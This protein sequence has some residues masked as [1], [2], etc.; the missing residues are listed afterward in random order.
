MTCRRDIKESAAAINNRP[1][2][3]VI[4]YRI[5]RYATFR[6]AM[7]ESINMKLLQ[8]SSRESNDYGIV[9]IE[10]WAYLA[11]ILAYY[12]ERIANEAYIRTT[13]LR[14]SVIALTEFIDY[15]LAPGVSA[16]TFIALIADKDKSG[17]IQRG[18]RVQSKVAGE[19]VKTFQT[20]EAITIFSS[21]NT[22]KLVSEKPFQQLRKDDQQ[23][24]LEGINLNMKMGDRILIIDVDRENDPSSRKWDV[25]Q[26]T[27]VTEYDKKTN[28]KFDKKI[29][30]NYEPA[31]N[32][33]VYAFREI[34]KP[35]GNNAPDYNSLTPEQKKIIKLDAS[36]TTLK[37]LAGDDTANPLI[38]LDSVYGKVK[39]GSYIAAINAIKPD[40]MELYKVKSVNEI[41]Y[42]N[43]ALSGKVT[44]AVVDKVAGMENFYIRE[45]ILLC[46]NESFIYATKESDFI[47]TEASQELEVKGVI[48]N[49]RIGAYIVISGEDKDGKPCSEVRRV[50]SVK[51]DTSTTKI[52]LDKALANSYK[53]DSAI[54][55]GNVVPASYGEPVKNEIVGSGD[56]SVSFQKFMLKKNPVTF[57]PD[58]TA[59]H[60]AKNSLELFVND[61]LW[62]ERDTFMDSGPADR[63]YITEI[64]EKDEM[65]VIFGDGIIGA[66]PPT[67]RDNITA[68]YR[69]GAG[70]NTSVNTI[71]GMVDSSPFLK[72]VLNPL[73]ASGGSEHE[74]NEKA[75]ENAPMQLRTFD[76]A[77]SLEDYA[78][79][80]RS[81]S[82]ITKARAFMEWE[83]EKQVVQL[84]VAL[85]QGEKL[86]D[87]IKKRLRAFLDMRRDANQPLSIKDYEP[88]KIEVAL[89]VT[90]KNAY[91]NTKVKKEVEEILGKFFAFEELDFGMSI[92]LSDIYAVVEG[93]E[94][95]AN[96]VVSKFRR[97]DAT[98]PIEEDILIKNTQIAQLDSL[99]VL[100]KGGIE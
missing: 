11:D 29:S 62:E 23:V 91:F 33:K 47:L 80:A 27:E 26:L 93:I 30:H 88:V 22:L 78:Y 79:I 6:S 68:Q 16:T 85:D 89:E 8:W 98:D 46:I 84:I 92:H 44:V 15:R 76:R 74:T 95:I 100:A 18:F 70:G 56:A 1:Y 10:M 19:P 71:T 64:N 13:V 48:E 60:G 7:L 24:I 73:P 75:K 40:I 69:R 94:G 90:V 86:A 34:A 41:F 67:G 38:H 2:M 81:F 31:Q 52:G 97:K 66:K 17:I 28:V 58:P 12:Q 42:I 35:F 77:I 53:K 63:H 5:G 82:G 39:M 50:A 55:Y 83:G 99:D 51:P 20:E 57:L 14:E 61:V 49:L 43:F 25:L 32:P 4:N 36:S 65:M 96:F 54:I 37:D 72:S 87:D 9:L 3:P 45:T 21:L 59:P